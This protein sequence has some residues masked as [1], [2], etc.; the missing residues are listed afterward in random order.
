MRDRQLATA[1]LHHSKILHVLEHCHHLLPAHRGKALEEVL[2]GITILQ[3][4][5]QAPHWHTR[6]SKDQFA[7]QNVRIL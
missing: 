7:T 1:T 4:I 3:V 5:E 2:D 6:A